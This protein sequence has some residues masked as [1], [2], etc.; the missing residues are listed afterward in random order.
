MLLLI[1]SSWDYNLFVKSINTIGSKEAYP[2]SYSTLGELITYKYYVNNTGNVDILG[3]ITV[4]DDQIPVPITISNSDLEPGQTVTGIVNYTIKQVD[5]NNGSVTNSASATNNGTKSNQTTATITAVQGSALNIT[6][7]ASPSSYDHVGDL[8][9]Y[10]YTV[11]NTGNV[12]IP[13]PIIVYDNKIPGGQIM[14]GT[15]SSVLA[16]GAS[17]QGTVTYTIT[18]ADIDIGSVTNSAFAT[19]PN[20]TVISNNTSVTVLA[21]QKPALKIEKVVSPRTYFTVGDLIEYFYTVTNKGNVDITGPI[22]ITDNM[23]GS[24]Q[25]SFSDL[26]P[27]QSVQGFHQYCISPRDI[28]VGFVINSAFA[29]GSFN[30]QTVTSNADTAIAKFFGPTSNL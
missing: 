26:A 16:Q 21:I 12:N 15:S 29:K 28:D 2:T 20:N 10:T 4:T 13:K 1:Y 11:T 14:I 18:Q 9:K 17:V 25:I 19:S 23:F 8:I 22:T 27:G 3:D 24:S 30:N 7:V 6:K 5:L